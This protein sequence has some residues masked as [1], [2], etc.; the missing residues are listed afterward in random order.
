MALFCPRNEGLEFYASSAGFKDKL[1]SVRD[2]VDFFDF[3]FR[4]SKSFTL[5]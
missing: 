1:I 5:L 2:D 3:L 4:F